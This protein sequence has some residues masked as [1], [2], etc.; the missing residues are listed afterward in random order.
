MELN[1][2]MHRGHRASELLENTLLQDALN[3]IE[4]EVVEQWTAC[5]ARDAEGKEALWQLMKTAQK[6]RGILSGYVET[7]KLASE[8]LKRFEDKKGLLDMLRRVA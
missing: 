8:N 2:Q 6:F 4:R 5:P 3:A 1:E 7:G